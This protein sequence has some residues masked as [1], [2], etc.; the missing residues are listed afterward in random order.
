[1]NKS[2][3]KARSIAFT[4][5]LALISAFFFFYTA[6]LLYVTNGLRR[7]RVGGQGA[8]VGAIVFPLI[9]LVCA[10][11]AWRCFRAARN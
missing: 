7:I 11:G 6:R 4:V 9:A 8:Y 2:I 3:S 10:W 5:F 1:M